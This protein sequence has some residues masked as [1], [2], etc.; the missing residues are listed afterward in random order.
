[1]NEE[2]NEHLLSYIV[3]GLSLS[4]PVGP[5]NAAQID[6]GIKTAFGMHGFSV[7]ALCGRAVYDS[8]LFR[9]VSILTA[10]FVKRFVALRF[11]C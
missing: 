2:A 1:M 5:V 7:S 10:P 4:A 3:L 9:A 6:K 11:S 8:D